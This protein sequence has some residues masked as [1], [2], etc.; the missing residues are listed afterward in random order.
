MPTEQRIQLGE[1]L[2]SRGLI[3]PDQL[4]SALAAQ[5]QF[6]GLLGSH[7]ILQG[8]VHRLQIRDAIAAQF[9]IG[10]RD[11][12]A[13][14]PDP[15]ALDTDD[16]VKILERGWL[17]LAWLDDRVLV[18]TDEVPTNEFGDR[19]SEA[20]GGVAV[21]FVAVT[22][23]DLDQAVTKIFRER[24]LYLAAEGLKAERPAFSAAL[25]IQRWQ[26]I[27]GWSA[28]VATLVA[29][30]IWPRDV[31]LVFVLLA[32]LLFL[33]GLLFKVLMSL[34]GMTTFARLSRTGEELLDTPEREWPT[35]TLLVPAFREHNIIGQVLENLGRLD[36]PQNKLQVLVLLE[37]TDS[38]TI[39]AAKQASPPDFVRIVIVPEGSPQTKPRACNYGLSLS[40]GE[41]LVIYDAEDMPEPRQLRKVLAQFERAASD[42][43][44]IQAPLNYFNAEENILTRMFALEYSAWFDAMLPGLDL[45]GFPIPLGGTSNHFRTASLRR[46][47]AWDP[48]N[49]TE[50]ADLGLRAEAMGYR[51]GVI[52]HTTTWEE[53]CSDARA[54]IR[55]RT[56]WI[57]GYMITALVHLRRPDNYLR[58]FGWRGVAGMVGLIAGTP[59]MFLAYP[60]VWGMTLL[61]A[62]DLVEYGNFFPAWLITA[63]AINAIV[64]NSL[65]IIITAIAG[66]RRHGW[67]ISGYALLNPF[68]WFMHSA[69]AW[70]A[71]Y[72]LLFSPFHWEKTPH[73]LTDTHAP[74]SARGL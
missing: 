19:V 3:T 34:L 28:G 18:A 6:G 43:V 5:R 31:L 15:Q 55:Q 48:Y 63:S 52:H 37:E 49:V 7:L 27:V 26:R 42:V 44:C 38:E 72:Q 69:A 33:S 67:R 64:G 45:T 73:G 70:R 60:V 1:L 39:S 40:S 14:P 23:W 74:Q 47:G 35:Y 57:K 17:P 65:A 58:N 36:Y 50:D 66:G 41:Y 29:L 61:G 24:L 22:W 68:Y 20:L 21:E 8:A 59:L 2:V 71:F 13:E 12:V 56:R 46:L 30:V 54:W 51:V 62:L 4:G 11:L 16:P 53:A 9:G 32:N 10:T 25:G